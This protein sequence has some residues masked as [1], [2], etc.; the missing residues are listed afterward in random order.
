MHNMKLPKLKNP[1]N[2]ENKVAITE[3]TIPSNT[4]KLPA[5]EIQGMRQEANQNL[6]D[7]YAHMGMTLE[8]IHAQI[9]QYENYQMM[10]QQ[11]HQ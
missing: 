4:N 9:R 5:V 8:Q 10:R 6:F 1:F 7:Q 11:P 3:S 2:R